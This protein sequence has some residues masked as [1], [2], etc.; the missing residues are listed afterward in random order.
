MSDL[1]PKTP[2]IVYFRSYL[3]AD[4]YGDNIEEPFDFTGASVFS[5]DPNLPAVELKLV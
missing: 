2:Q 4:P 3:A 5:Y 1:V